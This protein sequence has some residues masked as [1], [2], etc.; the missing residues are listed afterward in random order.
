MAAGFMPNILGRQNVRPVDERPLDGVRALLADSFQFA[1]P[2]SPGLHFWGGLAEPQR[3]GLSASLPR[4][5]VAGSDL[6]AEG[7]ETR[8]LGEAAERLSSLYDAG[9]DL[10]TVP[11]AQIPGDLLAAINGHA[12]SVECLPGQRLNDGEAVWVPAALCLYDPG[13]MVGA[14]GQRPAQVAKGI[15]AGPDW[16]SA[17][18]SAV[19]ELV[20]RDAAAL[21]WHGGKLP[22]PVSLDLVAD[23]RAAAVL[24]ALRMGQR[25]RTCWLL[26]I[27]TE[28]GLA[29]L[30]A[31][32]VMENGEGFACGLAAS[33]MPADAA[34]S[35]LIEMA[36]MELS[37]HL[38][39]GK[40]KALGPEGLTEADFRQIER[41][42]RI[43]AES[44]P[45]IV[46]SGAPRR[47]D[48]SQAGGSA[49]AR[50]AKQSAVYAVECTLPRLDIPVAA[51][52]APGLQPMDGATVTERLA[53][54]IAETGGG[55]QYH[56]GVHLI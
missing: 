30:A 18:D 39:R 13:A 19:A 22:S 42:V 11:A 49:V 21:W 7:A 44:C 9:R 47:H 17:V 3:A 40:A 37:Q 34:R 54:V 43:T 32:S 26:D 33:R 6:S 23:C 1:A 56:Q 45:L 15:A 29:I 12:D 25:G 41:S 27:S 48:I 20:E 16:Q 10:M 5:S 28:F 55:E 35:A 38:I 52:L 46:A 51:V 24:S 50:L 31:V 2:D 36:Q 8:C 53:A 4:I 14:A